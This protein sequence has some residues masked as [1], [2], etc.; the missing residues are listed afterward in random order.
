MVRDD[1]RFCDG[2][3]QKLPGGSMLSRQRVSVEEATDLGSSEP[4]N[5]DGTVTVDLCLQCRVTR[6]ERMK[7]S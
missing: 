4:L 7:R 5:P 6:S 3:H 1:G 2:C